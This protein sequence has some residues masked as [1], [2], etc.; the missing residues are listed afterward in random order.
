[1][2][3][4]Q[5]TFIAPKLT[6]SRFDDHSIPV[7]LLENFAVLQ[8]LIFDIAKDIYLEQN[9]ERQRV[10]KGFTDDVYLKLVDVDPGSAIAKFI[11]ASTIGLSSGLF[12][13]NIEYF[14]Q[15]KDKLIQFV[16]QSEK[17]EITPEFKDKYKFYFNRLGKNLLEN[18]E[19]IL[20]PN[21]TSQYKSAINI[22]TRK[23]IIL[24][25]N[26]NREYSSS[27][28]INA[29]VHE[30]DQ[31]KKTF[32]ITFG[33][34]KL[35]NIPCGDFFHEILSAFVEFKNN[36]L[37]SIKATGIYNSNDKL[38]K[39]DEIESANILDP[40]DVSVRLKNLS[41]LKDGWY[42]G[43]GKGLNSENLKKFEN[44][45]S[46]FYDSHLPLPAIF[47]TIDG[48]IQL[49][50]SINQSEISLEVNTDDFTAE[51]FAS[52]INSDDFEEVHLS[53]LL[54]EHAWETINKDISL[55]MIK[56]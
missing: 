17:K 1:M 47:P 22:T 56:V 46:S 39:I 8:D 24:S 23:Q 38:V 13:K 9:P 26:N 2:E 19:L 49:E 53:S 48:H 25:S 51:Y 45:F 31:D 34:T 18:E 41:E 37:I 27:I 10:P 54:Q 12:P 16:E 6:G 4:N 29:L 5:N 50:W 33:E 7:D 20:N 28:T 32:G 43:E 15:A 30:L 21:S 3:N 52:D 42:H 40:L 11:L 35:Q 44:A 36:A 55:K 14:E